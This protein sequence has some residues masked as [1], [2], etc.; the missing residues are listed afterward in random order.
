MAHPVAVQGEHDLVPSHDGELHC[1][2]DAELASLLRG[3]G[4]P[5]LF[6]RC[7]CTRAQESEGEVAERDRE[8]EIKRER[9]GGGESGCEELG[10]S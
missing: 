10:W 5:A 7:V 8:G 1:S 6:V 9:E 4:E 3:G 2:D